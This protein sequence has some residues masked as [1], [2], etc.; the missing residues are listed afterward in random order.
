MDEFFHDPRFI[1]VIRGLSLFFRERV[2]FFISAVTHY[3]Y[4]TLTA[5]VKFACKIKENN[6]QYQTRNV[7]GRSIGSETPHFNFRDSVQLQIRQPIIM[8]PHQN[9]WVNS[10]SGRAQRL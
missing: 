8:P 5:A 1:R 3:E 9:L 4:P 7:Q 6:I 10:G 2:Q